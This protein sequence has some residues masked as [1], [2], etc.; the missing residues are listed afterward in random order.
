MNTLGLFST[1]QVNN[2]RWYYYTDKMGII[3]LQVSWLSFRSGV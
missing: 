3:V 1:V 2:E